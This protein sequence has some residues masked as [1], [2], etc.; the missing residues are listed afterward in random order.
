MYHIFAYIYLLATLSEVPPR[1]YCDIEIST[2]ELIF[3]LGT[4][5]TVNIKVSNVNKS[6]V[7]LYFT[8]HNEEVVQVLPSVIPLHGYDDDYNFTVYA[9]RAGHSEISANSSDP[10]VSVKHLYLVA[11]VH[12]EKY[13]DIASQISGWIYFVTW[14]LSY[15]PQ[16]YTN[17]KRKS[18]IGFS[19]DYLALNV[20]G[21]LSFGVFIQSVFFAP[22]IQE[23]YFEQ[24]SHGL[25]PVK[26]NDVFY[27]LHGILAL[28]VTG[29]QCLIYERGSQTISLITRLMLGGF[30]IFYVVLFILRAVCVIQWL[31]F[32]YFSSYVKLVITVL[33]YI[34]QA[35]LNWKRK[36]TSGW[37]IGV[38]NLNLAGGVCSIGQMALDA[39][40][41]DDWKSIFG[42]PTKFGLGAFTVLFQVLFMVQHYILYR[43]SPSTDGKDLM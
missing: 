39:Y 6:G 27:N 19:F 37:S 1:V 17:F 32:L 26:V 21:Y 7:I 43:N 42:N 34:P 16:I 22:A 40:N 30:G 33:K 12:K 23:E 25:L 20:V 11:N 36:S 14:A 35:Y 24:H 4:Q 28:L 2:K 31:D 13:I 15:Y 9:S 8:V 41:Y 10:D 38:V 29:L 3:P 5:E 18:V